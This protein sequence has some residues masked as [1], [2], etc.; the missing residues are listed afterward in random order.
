MRPT[1]SQP[2]TMSS[3]VHEPELDELLDDPIMTL[4]LH[5][6]GLRHADM[7]PLIQEWQRGIAA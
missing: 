3:A 6:D 2:L 1:P 4:L 7:L 5:S